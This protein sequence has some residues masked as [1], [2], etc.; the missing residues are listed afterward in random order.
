MDF[1]DE[2]NIWREQFKKHLNVKDLSDA[3]KQDVLE[4]VKA[5]YNSL[6]SY[7]ALSTDFDTLCK[8]FDDNMQNADISSKLRKIVDLTVESAW[9]AIKDLSDIESQP[10][11][12]QIERAHQDALNAL[13]EARASDTANQY[14]QELNDIAIMINSCSNESDAL[15]VRLCYTNAKARADEIRFEILSKTKSGGAK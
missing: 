11:Q 4:I 14:A 2:L 9:E 5:T 6:V 15:H 7:F 8:I 1:L 3:E 12:E 13:G 10:T